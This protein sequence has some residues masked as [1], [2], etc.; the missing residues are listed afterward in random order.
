MEERNFKVMSLQTG[1]P[2]AMKCGEGISLRTG[3]LGYRNKEEFVLDYTSIER[4]R[5]QIYE[6]VEEGR[7]QSIK[8]L[9]LP[10]RIKFLPKD[11]GAPSYLEIRLQDMDPLKRSGVSQ[12]ALYVRP[13]L[14][15][16]ALIKEV[17]EEFE[18][19]AT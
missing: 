6:F 15:M 19:K 17:E 16:Y 18:S 12:H 8:E 2:Q 4:Y 3:P 13:M 7:L 1:L 11:G 14:L 9:Y 10:L 5:Q